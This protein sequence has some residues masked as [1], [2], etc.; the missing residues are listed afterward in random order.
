MNKS[1][2]TITGQSSTNKIIFKGNKYE[3]EVETNPF[4]ITKQVVVAD[5]Y[6]L[7][8]RTISNPYFYFIM[9]SVGEM[10]TYF[11]T[12]KILFRNT[13]YVILGAIVGII[14][15]SLVSKKF[16]MLLKQTAQNHG[17]EHKVIMAYENKDLEN[18]EKYNRF[19]EG[20][21]SNLITGVCLI[22]GIWS[23][24]RFPGTVSLIFV[25]LYITSK[26]FRSIWFNL[27]GKP[28][29]HIITAEPSPEILDSARKGLQ[30]L[31]ELERS[32]TK[33]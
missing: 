27:I 17:A 18:A 21:G 29:Q 12:G 8:T 28:I 15:L 7:I 26:S 20:C 10:V 23:I 4:R 31:I 24:I 32:A 25:F 22:L 33:Q 14:I 16:H 11:L 19:T 30:K 1:I 3:L 2:K 5:E 13:S 9:L 6:G